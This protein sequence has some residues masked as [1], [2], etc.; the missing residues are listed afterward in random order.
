VLQASYAPRERHAVLS[1]S[2]SLVTLTAST[3]GV[4]G[5]QGGLVVARVARATPGDQ[6]GSS[7]SRRRKPRQPRRRSARTHTGSTTIGAHPRKAEAA[8]AT[9]RPDRHG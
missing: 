2:C 9:G 7:F 6:D 1:A 8:D 5:E 4:H 3:G